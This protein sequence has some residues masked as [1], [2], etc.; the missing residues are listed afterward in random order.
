MSRAEK[1]VRSKT[2][3][4]TSMRAEGSFARDSVDESRGAV[5]PD[6]REVSGGPN[7]GSPEARRNR[8]KFCLIVS[9][10]VLTDPATPIDNHL[11]LHAW[12]RDIIEDYVR[13]QAPGM[14]EVVILNRREFLIF[15]GRRSHG[16]GLDLD[17]IV[18][19]ATLM[20][21]DV[22]WVGRMALMEARPRTVKDGKVLIAT[23]NEFVRRHPGQRPRR[24][25]LERDHLHR[26][27][28]VIGTP[29]TSPRMRARAR[30]ADRFIA[31]RLLQ[32][33]APS[34]PREGSNPPPAGRAWAPVDPLIEDAHYRMPQHLADVR[35]PRNRGIYEARMQDI[36]MHDMRHADQGLAD[37]DLF[38]PP[39][40]RYESALEEQELSDDS[41]VHGDTSDDDL[42][43]DD[44][45][46]YDADTGRQITL[47]G[48]NRRR[49]RGRRRERRRAY[50]V[51]NAG[52]NNNGGP[53]GQPRKL[54]MGM[55]RE[56]DKDSIPYDT[57][58]K[59]VAQYIG[60]RYSE[61]L[62]IDSV[63]SSLEGS[64]YSSAYLAYTKHH[65]LEAILGALDKVY[66]GA[67]SFCELNLRL[68]SI[69]QRY[70]E[71][72]KELY[73]RVVDLQSKIRER[74]PTMYPGTEME[75][76][77]KNAF[78][79]GLHARYQPMVVHHR[80]DPEKEMADI[81]VA[82]REI[83]ENHENDRRGREDYP[84]KYGHNKRS[85][86]PEYGP[87]PRDNHVRE[88]KPAVNAKAAYVDPE[89]G[90]DEDLSDDDRTLLYDE[91]IYIGMV[92]AAEDNERLTFKCFNCAAE[93]HRWRDCPQPLREE[94]AQLKD[95]R[96]PN[97]A[98]LNK[99]GGSAI[100]GVRAPLKAP[101]PVP[102]EAAP[103]AQ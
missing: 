100:K 16:E 84:S 26:Q 86:V 59:D 52:N 64:A 95:K 85:Y 17:T 88:A 68:C 43:W 25:P 71:S 93:G 56:G 46:E 75:Q 58:R 54:P 18:P 94:L 50:R 73:E 102:H 65:S 33:R 101:G 29:S 2:A 4:P 82:V 45:V 70:D 36:R 34:T 27:P 66:G 41:A 35:A 76:V 79:G 67:T 47:A 83:E 11:P 69:K 37:R 81:L 49:N 23:Q 98:R 60:Q 74:Y 87:K 61:R 44:A 31:E 42:E 14:S 15:F 78:F 12:T 28:E 99:F 5:G 97:P 22:K 53:R 7:P 62:I 38:A 77:G 19:L 6:P 91:G 13:P 89:L 10:T 55:F 30:R 9:V 72:A 1:S 57:W 20:T 21:H 3:T 63:L 40:D 92:R 39:D 32:G 80:D 103:A 51:R 90:T 48:R 8:E 96:V 24:E